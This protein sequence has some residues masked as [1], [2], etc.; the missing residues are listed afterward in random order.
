M[1]KIIDGKLVASVVREQVKQETEALFKT[2]NRVPHLAVVI[3]GEVP[4]SWSYVRSKEKF[5][6]EMGFHSVT[7]PLPKDITEKQLLSHIEKLNQDKNINGIL[8][9]LPLPQHIDEQNVIA[10]IAV[11]KDVD[12]FHPEQ[13]GGL[14]IGLNTLEPC[15]PAGIM[16]LLDYYDIDVSGKHAV[17]IGR[18]NIV[19]KPIANMLLKR[20]ATVTM[21]HSRTT[22]LAE[23]TRLAD[24]LIVAIGV[25]HFL[26]ADMVKTGAVIIDVGINRNEEGKL[27][28][29]VEYEKVFD[30]ASAIT[31][32]PGGVGPMTIAMLLKNTLEAFKRQN[33]V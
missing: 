28:G 9:Q 22:N 4:A 26:T 7:V 6:K 10:A 24:I 1:S 27:V 29:D 31:P 3:V 23:M 16:A 15:T 30:V 2:T 32:V 20:D 8:V 25:P 19:G 11:A 18:S 33:Q 13:V 14:S 5:A 17:I 21:T 12:G